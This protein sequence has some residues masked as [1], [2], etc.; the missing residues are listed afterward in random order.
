M[1]S[2][3]PSGV[4]ALSN[5]PA[6]SNGEKGP[7]TPHAK[8][9]R[10]LSKS[11][12]RADSQDVDGSKIWGI[13]SVRDHQGEEQRVRVVQK[14][15]IENLNMV[16]VSWFW[17]WQSTTH[18]V[19]LRHGRRSGIRKIYVDKQEIERVKTVKNMLADNGSTHTFQV[20]GKT[21]EIVIN[22]KGSSGFTYQLVI[23]GNAI[24]QN[25]V[26]PM[27]DLPLDIGTRAIELP[28]TDD[29]LGMTLRNNPLSTGVV[30]W[31]V[32][33]GKA[34]EKA[35]IRVGDVVL[36]IEAHLIDSIDNLVEYVSECRGVVHMEVA[37]TAPSRIVSMVKSKDNPKVGLGLQTTSCGIGILVTEID[38]DGTAAQSHLKT[39]DSILSIDDV[40]PTSPKHAV[41]LIMSS[42]Y[43][44]KF[45]VIGHVPAVDA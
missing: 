2:P 44:V 13:V 1:S 34:A 37:G 17:Q 36:S 15:E 27:S 16:K 42:E 9:G 26:G 35:G 43:A 4:P 5:L 23:D 29:G 21:A 24:E 40:V 39:G 45:V 8:S 3:N 28:K 38:L 11:V 30:V 6:G 10:R 41:Q 12:L 32:E 19:E 14:E 22:P 18:Q 31:S 25:I 33:P 7:P 20:G